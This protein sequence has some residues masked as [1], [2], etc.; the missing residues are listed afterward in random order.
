MKLKSIN[1]AGLLIFLLAGI[2]IS[3]Q[4]FPLKL[5][6]QHYSTGYTNFIPMS[7]WC[8][9]VYGTTN[10]GTPQTNWPLQSCITNW[11]LGPTNPVNNMQYY[12]SAVINLPMAPQWFVY[13]TTSNFNAE[14][15]PSNPAWNPPVGTNAVN[16]LLVK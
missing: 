15:G 1:L 3:A 4:Q 7:N 5:G 14:Y 11:N 16:A 9:N 2:A 10:L 6:F 12:T 13:I 8:Y